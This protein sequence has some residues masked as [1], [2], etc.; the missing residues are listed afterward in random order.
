MLFYLNARNSIGPNSPRGKFF[1]K[2]GSRKGLN[3]N[4]AR[5]LLELHTVGVDGGYSQE[6]IIDLAKA[7]TGWTVNTS[8]SDMSSEQRLQFDSSLH[9]PGTR[10]VLGRRYPDD[11]PS[12]LKHI[13]RD[14]ASMPQTATRVA[15]R[16]ATHFIGDSAPAEFRRNLARIYLETDGDLYQISKFVVNDDIIWTTEN[17]KIRPPLELLCAAARLLEQPPLRPAPL[18]AL[19]AM[20]QPYMQPDGPNGWNES[21]N[22]WG[23]PDSIKSRLDWSAEFA[24]KQTKMYSPVSLLQKAFGSDA[25]QETRQAVEEA[26]TAAQSLTLLLMSPE[27]QRR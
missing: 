5:E 21:D 3:E 2:K 13:L 27:I 11:G 4:Q 12:Q 14:L 17:R 1:T 8:H 7:M 25:S 22:A 23:A 9:E 15:N 26:P 18:A 16:L 10:I 19:T 6:D 20:G 24:E